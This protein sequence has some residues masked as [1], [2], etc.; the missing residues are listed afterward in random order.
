[1]IHEALIVFLLLSN[2]YSLW[3]W[4]YALDGWK[5]ALSQW[6]ESSDKHQQIFEDFSAAIDKER[7]AADALI[8]AERLGRLC[9]RCGQKENL[10]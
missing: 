10:Q 9:S 7:L 6:R 1:V 3:K 4:R 5:R 2:A 8:E